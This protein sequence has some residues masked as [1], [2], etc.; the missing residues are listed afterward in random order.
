MSASPTDDV[1]LRV[2]AGNG[3]SIPTASSYKAGRPEPLAPPPSVRGE[4]LFQR[5]DDALA[6]LDGWVSRWLPPEYN[7]L[8]QAG[9]A[10]N[11]ALLVAIATGILMLLWYSPSLQFAYPSLVAIQG[12]T[13][14]GWVRAL[15][16]YSSDL[17]M[18]LLIVH[19]GR[20]FVARKFAG[21]RWVAWVSGIG[22][23]SLVWLIGWTGYW[24]VWDQPAQQVAVSSIQLLDGLP[25]FGEPLG[26]LFVSDRTVPSLLFFVVFFLHMLLP[27][28]IAVGLAVHLAR[29]SRA[30]LLP[31]RGLSLALVLAL[32]LAALLVPAPLD[33]PAE[34]AVK[35]EAISIDAWFLSP[36]ALALRF[37]HAGLWVALVSGLLLGALVP[38]LLGRRRK[39]QTFQAAVDVSRCHACTQCVQDCP[40]DAITMVARTDGKRFDAQAQVDPARCVG[41]GVCAGSCDSEGIALTWFDTRIQE[42]RMERAIEAAQAVG[43][44]KWVALVGGEIRGPLPVLPGYTIHRV[45]TASWVRPKFVER[46]ITR[47]VRGVLVVRDARGEAAARDGGRWVEARLAGER[48]PVLRPERIAGGRWCVVDFDPSRPASLSGV[49]ERFCRGPVRRGEP[50][51]R[52]AILAAIA[53]AGVLTVAA[54]APSHL[55]VVNPAVATPELVLSIKAFGE[56]VA[57]P[58]AAVSGLGSDR[59]GGPPFNQMGAAAAGLVFDPAGG[60]PAAPGDAGKPVHMRGVVI[61]KPRRA[62][63]I[64]RLTIDG[65][66]EERAF[67]AKGFSRDGPAIGEW[68]RAWEAGEHQVVIEIAP[69]GTAPVARWQGTLRAVERRLNVVMYDPNAGFTVE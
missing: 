4:K 14:G 21:A 18:L 40:F 33:A 32:G 20:V 17:M 34:M 39:P 27:L 61:E 24:L 36:L 67:P 7:A 58:E 45:P 28:M 12:S 5:V 6:G 8:A 2:S 19:A 42:G 35:A 64:V 43:N 22:M 49:A 53:L 51:R 65:V 46:L 60:T 31:Q 47:G 62:D 29:V 48:K 57:R 38:W 13:T 11:V 69:G 52:T 63:V 23:L 54:V 3:M 41:C 9:A 15:H 1:A 55:R 26:R 44:S 10:A 56:R 37:R 59:D 50:P 30:R 16:R 25:I 66:R 68:R